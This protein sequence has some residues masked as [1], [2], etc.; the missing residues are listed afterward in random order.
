MRKIL[1]L[2]LL[3]PAMNAFSQDILTKKNGDEIQVKVLEITNTDVKYKKWSNQDGPSYTLPKSDVFMI[4]YKNGEKEVFKEETS[5]MVNEATSVNNNNQVVPSNLK[6]EDFSIP[7]E[8]NETIKNKYR[9]NVAYADTKKMAKKKDAKSAYC[10]LDICKDAIMADKNVEVEIKTGNYSYDY[11]AKSLQ[12]WTPR[13][14]SIVTTGQC[15]QITLRN[16]TDKT[17]FID[18]GNS[19]F[20]RGKESSPYY[21]PT[22]VSNTNGSSQGVSVNAGSVAGALGVGG[23]LGTLANGVN[24]GGG[25]SSGSITTTYSQRVVSIPPKS[26]IKLDPQCLFPVGCGD[27]YGFDSWSIYTSVNKKN[28]TNC[29]FPNLE[30]KW[31]DIKTWTEKESPMM[32]GSFFTY[33]MDD[34]FAQTISIK[35]MMYLQK[36]YALPRPVGG[37]TIPTADYSVLTDNFIDALFFGVEFNTQGSR[38]R[39]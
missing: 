30:L 38:I 31:G 6:V 26:S 9:I 12:F 4:K 3:L 5:K 21:I 32:V 23:A 17:L 36:V 8:E 28:E 25:T 24:V 13:K 18:L 19:F 33:S 10:Q 29:Y 22:S 7:Y 14:I 11:R 37:Y 1:L 34:S 35:T 15:V 39:R 2:G 16:K 20:I 27:T